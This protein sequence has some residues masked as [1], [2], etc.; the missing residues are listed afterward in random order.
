MSG[1]EPRE[2][3]EAVLGTCPRCET[4]VLPRHLGILYEPA[5]GWPRI[6]AECPGCD[7]VVQPE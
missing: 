3:P 4:R 2:N 1:N 7:A 5:V 6:L